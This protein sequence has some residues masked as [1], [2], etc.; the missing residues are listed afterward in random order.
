MY[1][2]ELTIHVE[3]HYNFDDDMLNN[4]GLHTL[5]WE[6]VGM[7]ATK[8]YLKQS[9]CFTSGLMLIYFKLH[10]INEFVP[11]ILLC[12]SANCL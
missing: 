10:L 9:I 11:T 12:Y 1:C 8:M 5:M 7:H 2:M 3:N 4:G 6:F